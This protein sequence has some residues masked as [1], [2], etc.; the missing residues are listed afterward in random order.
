MVCG[1]FLASDL[2]FPCFVV[3]HEYNDMQ[4]HD[5]HQR[6]SHSKQELNE[7]LLSGTLS[8]VNACFNTLC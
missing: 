5:K 7:G 6:S 3:V 2:T 1:D 8:I 4:S